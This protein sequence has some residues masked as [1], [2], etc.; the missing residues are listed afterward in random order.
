[1]EFQWSK[2]KGREPAVL[3]NEGK[4]LQSENIGKQLKPCYSINTWEC[5]CFVLI[6]SNTW[7]KGKF[8]PWHVYLTPIP[9]PWGPKGDMYSDTC[10]GDPSLCGICSCRVWKPMKAVYGPT[11]SIFSSC[12]LQ[13]CFATLAG[14]PEPTWLVEV[15]SVKNLLFFFFFLPTCYHAIV[16]FMLKF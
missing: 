7:S 3:E 1:M 6:F 2:A 16:N 10:R 8:P 12:V 5:Q 4:P 9:R 14:L 15:C 11:R 13:S